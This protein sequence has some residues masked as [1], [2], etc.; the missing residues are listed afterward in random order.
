[1]FMYGVWLLTALACA[2]LLMYRYWSHIKCPIGL[3][4]FGLTFLWVG[5]RFAVSVPARQYNLFSFAPLACLLVLAVIAGPEKKATT[6]N[7]WLR[8]LPKVAFLLLVGLPALGTV[9][10]VLHCAISRQDGLGYD[11]ARQLVDEIRRN[12]ARIT[13]SRDLFVLAEDQHGIE[14]FDVAR[15]RRGESKPFA[16]DLLILQQ[17]KLATTDPPILDGYELESDYFSHH[18]YRVFGLPVGTTPEAY[19]LAVYRKVARNAAQ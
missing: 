9:R 6:N 11:D 16:S 8:L 5:G 7:R 2:L 10:L 19:N 1:V 3:I 4:A 13:L 15:W 18:T 17:S 14:Y 12:S